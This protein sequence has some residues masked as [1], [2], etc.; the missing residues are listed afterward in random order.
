MDKEKLEQIA[1]GI[2]NFDLMSLILSIKDS[3]DIAVTSY[4]LRE[5]KKRKGESKVEPFYIM[6]NNIKNATYLLN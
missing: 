3:Q 6:L 1:E 2:L 5:Y 4:N